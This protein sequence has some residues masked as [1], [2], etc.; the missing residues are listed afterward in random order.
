MA[1]HLTGVCYHNTDETVHCLTVLQLRRLHRE[2][3][4]YASPA[5]T[6]HYMDRFI[7]SDSSPWWVRRPEE[8]TL[9]NADHK[10]LVR[11]KSHAEDLAELTTP[12]VYIDSLNCFR[13]CANAHNRVCYLPAHQ[14]QARAF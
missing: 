3:K 2:L 10:A 11:V 7:A 8:E 9:A 14:D 4:D 12:K 1:V 13:S 6:T 5:L